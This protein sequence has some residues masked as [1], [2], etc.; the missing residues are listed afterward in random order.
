MMKT[1]IFIRSSVPAFF[2]LTAAFACAAAGTGKSSDGG[3]ADVLTVCGESAF[4]ASGESIV[5]IPGTIRKGWYL[6]T[7]R[8]R[9]R[10]FAHDG[11][12]AMD[13][14]SS[15]RKTSLSCYE[16]MP[17]SGDWTP[18]SI[19]LKSDGDVSA[20]VRIGNWIGT[21][22]GASLELKDVS[23]RQF[24]FPSGVDWLSDA[25]FGESCAG[26][27]PPNWYWHNGKTGEHDGEFTDGRLRTANGSPVLVLDGS[28]S[29]REIRRH[30][31]PMPEGGELIFTVKARSDA[32]CSMTQHIVQD[33]WG[34]RV[35]KRFK[36]TNEWKEYEAVLALP[37]SR[38]KNWFFLRLDVSD[39][40]IQLS[41]PKLIWNAPPPEDKSFVFRNIEGD[42][43]N[44]PESMRKASAES[45]MVEVPAAGGIL[46]PVKGKFPA[47]YYCLSGE[48]WTPAFD[49][50]G[51]FAMDARTPDGK[52]AFSNYEWLP[53]ADGWSPVRLYFKTGRTSEV[54]LRLGNWTAAGNGASV[55]LRNLKVEKF[56]FTDSMEFISGDSFDG[57]HEGNMPPGWTWHG[58]RAE[59]PENCALVPNTGFRTGSYILTLA[60]DSNPRDVRHGTMPMPEG[61]ELVFSIWARSGSP[62]SITQ[63][64]VQDGWS[65]RVEKKHELSESWKKYEA[66][67]PLPS[68][69]E[70]DWF[71][72]RLD[73]P[74]GGGPVEI[75]SP[76]LAWR[77]ESGGK[78][79]EQNTDACARGWQGVPGSNLLY[80]PDFELGG[81]GF[82]YDFS[83]PKS[84]A[85]YISAGNAMPIVLKEGEGVDG[86]T[87]AFVQGTSLR[88]YCFPVTVGQTYTL[89]ADMKAPPGSSSA[90]CRV[91]AFD[92]EW[93]CALSADA[94]DI[95]PEW[96]RFRWTFKWTP[97]NI[98]KRGYVRFDSSGVMIDRIQ[99]VQGTQAEY[100]PPP[101]M[102]GLVFD[103]WQYFVR[104]RDKAEA[105]LRI[106]PGK[107]SNEECVVQAIARDAWGRESWTFKKQV[108]L[109]K[110]SE[111]S[112]A[113]PT[114]SLGVFH[115]ELS[116]VSESREK[117]GIGI[118]RYAVIDPPYIQQT[119]PG[120]P[121]LA[122]I[123]QESFNFPDW[124][125]RD[126]AAIQTDL[127]IRLNRFFASVP[128]DLTYPVPNEFI[129]II[130][131][132]C[133]PFN[134]AG[135]DLLPCV[136]L[137]PPA[138]ANA[139]DNTNMPGPGVM[140]DYRN[141]LR[142]YVSAFKDSVKYWEIFNEPNLW[143]VR[144]GPNAGKRT[145]FPEK[146]A[147]FQKTAFEVIKSVDPDAQVVCC[148]LN[149]VDFDWFEKWMN[150]GGGKYMDI[151]SFHPYGVT[152]FY[153]QGEQL[154]AAMKR[155]GV[156]AGLINSEKYYGANLFYD[157]QGYEETR[158]GYYLPFDGEL[159]TAGRSIQHFLTHAAHR[160]PVCFFN[161]TGTIS[162]RGPGTELF[163]YD[164]FAAY[165]AAIRFAVPA[166][167][168]EHI[169][170][171]P[172]AA[173]ILF[174]D[175]P[176]GPL[177]AIWATQLNLEGTLKLSGEFSAYDIMGNPL[178][179]QQISNGVRL[180]A[181]PSY[182]VFPAGTPRERI[183]RMVS[184]AELFGMGSPFKI[185][186]SAQEN[187]K[188]KVLIA[189]QRNKPQTGTVSIVK[190][191]EGKKL[192]PTQTFEIKDAAGTAS[193]IFD[194]G[195]TGFI[196]LHE[197]PVS[198]LAESGDEFERA[199]CAI[200][201][202]FATK[203]DGIT[204]D[205][206]LSDWAGAQWVH[207]GKE[208]LSKVFSPGLVNTGEEDL[209]AK[210]AVKYNASSIA[211]A[212][213]VR[214]D[215]HCASE[216]PL[217]AWQGDSLQ[218][219]L[220]PLADAMPGA[221]NAQD[222]I[223]YAFALI[224]GRPRVWLEK[225]AEG[226]YRDKANKTDGL[227]DADVQCAILRQGHDTIYE[228]VLPLNPC[229]PGVNFKKTG[230]IGF[231]ILVNDNDGRGRKQGLTA[232]P[233]GTEP[234][235][236]PHLY[237][238][239]VFE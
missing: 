14:R 98:Q 45:G 186:A 204:A 158:R 124:L 78:P 76:V 179:E 201:P 77:R 220:D 190:L 71:F 234:Y 145:M 82:F 214:D 170:L 155:L 104:G 117:A 18:F 32:G 208:N 36:I 79:A 230:A 119:S 10:G 142:Q 23:L 151:V 209:S 26:F 223:E 55:R 135:I 20:S 99:V 106:A 166:G 50:D 196:P 15:D 102:L 29:L 12:F 47:G 180:A 134:D 13:A 183:L 53:A 21:S 233:A 60:G 206:N 17:A 48:Y 210:I 200:R 49:G 85:N 59:D 9:T 227:E 11:K 44:L 111:F 62:A 1:S 185:T 91:Y 198:V 74:A 41:E 115:V 149:N 33:G 39:G 8:Y 146:Y 160:I 163:L 203:T 176:G 218:L 101:V 139:S 187:G 133:A 237:A 232:S 64:I 7:G 194:I 4:P 6:L 175:S 58:K 30:A 31:M 131:K 207:L 37:E 38:E 35:E 94:K 96:K 43:F 192:P 93:K 148:A 100:E 112:I 120:K 54:S 107:F 224:N 199:E 57:G 67:L 83:W 65:R 154:K 156:T 24:G 215:T 239:L 216:S 165:S 189:G 89:S 121:G 132:K 27:M 69:R 164:F 130:R 122:G 181:D 97:E 157:R 105:K 222:D 113:I 127:G 184:N 61:G 177:L 150:A 238:D 81:T 138:A 231:S 90:A 25:P 128:P 143:R 168:G 114:N 147:L 126:H 51:K 56:E 229:I 191:P 75:A 228:I 171:G 219:F 193:A 2:L 16:W 236:A 72:L 174:P 86:G 84:Y 140:Q 211:I 92:S 226:N 80:N 52:G 19:Y 3:R 129:E 221:A 217:L 68:K 188:I 212:A 63:H 5:N 88:A 109:D 172:T 213:V 118:S 225:G 123:C 153:S 169:S 167:N 202:I 70:R 178:T 42:I 87:C 46:L 159:K 197:Y 173:G 144:S 103:R 205:G 73:V 116:A 152:D 108:T 136:E 162:R 235:G 28:A 141:A 22:A 66:I 34:R 161:P 40:K 95:G 110:T 125:C 182:I 137:I 195:E